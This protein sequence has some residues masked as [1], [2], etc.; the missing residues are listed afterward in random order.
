M[1]KVFASKDLKVS[2]LHLI[3]KLHNQCSENKNKHIAFLS[4]EINAEE[5]YQEL[6]IKE[7]FLVYDFV[8]KK[9]ES[10]LNSSISLPLNSM[11]FID[12]PNK[13]LLRSNDENLDIQHIR[14]IIIPL[15]Y[16]YNVKN[17]YID[18]FHKITCNVM[19]RDLLWK[20]NPS[21]F[22]L[23]EDWKER[24]MEYKMAL[25]FYMS[26]RFE[27][28]FHIGM[29]L[30]ENELKPKSIKHLNYGNIYD[31]IDEIKYE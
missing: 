27:I 14:N 13:S 3:K 20:T 22:P 18:N 7:E 11:F 8:D 23:Y 31:M 26:R 25:L 5:F 24:Q 15:K 21:N 1:I 30:E 29:K 17:I 4:T 28:N 9:E 2:S 16:K 12:L 19:G 6:E 10:F